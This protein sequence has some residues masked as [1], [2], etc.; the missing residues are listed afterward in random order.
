MGFNHSKR[1]HREPVV[2]NTYWVCAGFVLF[3]LIPLLLFLITLL[4]ILLLLENSIHLC[5]LG[6]QDNTKHFSL[7]EGNSLEQWMSSPVI[8]QFPNYIL[9]V[10][11]RLR[12]RV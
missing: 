9:A 4:L 6:F 8:W 10:F 12:W 3:V 1:N 2:L 11:T 5:K 7:L